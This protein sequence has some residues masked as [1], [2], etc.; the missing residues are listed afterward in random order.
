MSGAVAHF[1]SRRSDLLIVERPAVPQY[2]GGRLIGTTPGRYHQ[3]ED[4]RL[5]VEGQKTIDFLRGRMKAVNSP[6]IWEIDATDVP[7]ST[8]LLVELVT[9]EIPRVREILAAE[10]A[11]PARSEVVRACRSA[12]EKMNV[13]ERGP[14]SVD[15]APRHAKV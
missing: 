8:E 11:G 9:A 1:A 3:F 5:R 14:G 2:E 6:E 12:L 4:H 7:P 10:E 15:P 13:A